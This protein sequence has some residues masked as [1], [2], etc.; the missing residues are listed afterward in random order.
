[1][2][3]IIAFL[4]AI[5]VAGILWIVTVSG[6]YLLLLSLFSIADDPG[7]LI[8]FIFNWVPFLIG[9]AISGF[10]TLFTIRLISGT[11]SSTPLFIAVGVISFIPAFLFLLLYSFDNPADLVPLLI[12]SIFAA[13]FG[14]SGALSLYKRSIR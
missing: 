1:M 6:I 13:G 2:K 5:V 4:I 3:L 10:G 9:G 12:R 7:R 14:Y 8:N 11:N